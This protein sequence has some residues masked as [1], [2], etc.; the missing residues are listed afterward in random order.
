MTTPAFPRSLLVLPVLALTACG[1]G[2]VGRTSNLPSDIQRIFVSPLENQ[3]T[4][5]QVELLLTEA[6]TNELV[7]RRRFTVVRTRSEADAVLSGA[8]TAFAVRPVT[9]DADGRAE[10]YEIAVRADMLFKRS[11]AAEVG[12]V[13]VDR[14]EGDGGSVRG[15]GCRRAAVTDSLRPTGLPSRAIDPN[16]RPRGDQYVAEAILTQEQANLVVMMIGPLGLASLHAD[17]LSSL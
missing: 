15:D 5:S 4:R 13:L 9:F 7:T 17:A 8:V 12:F 10:E 14:V 11:D 6:I 1:Y 3:T 16:H 2:L